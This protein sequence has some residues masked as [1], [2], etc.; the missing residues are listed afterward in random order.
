MRK[1]KL[2]TFIGKTI[3]S[4]NPEGKL[5]V[6]KDLRYHQPVAVIRVIVK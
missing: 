6:I 2:L 5:K 3:R 1:F 4:G